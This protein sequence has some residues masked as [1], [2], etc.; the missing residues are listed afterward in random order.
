MRL[1]GSP[2]PT[3]FLVALH[4]G[5]YILSRAQAGDYSSAAK[6]QAARGCGSEV[7]GVDTVLLKER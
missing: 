5:T 2:A 3:S 1:E 6:G 7:V 4:A